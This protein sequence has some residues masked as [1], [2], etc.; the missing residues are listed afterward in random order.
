MDKHFCFMDA[1][2]PCDEKC[3]A[4]NIKAKACKL[5]DGIVGLNRNAGII[6]K[7]LSSPR[8]PKA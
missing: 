6:A 5:V 2:R 7:W 3:K 4:Y 1:A 8:M